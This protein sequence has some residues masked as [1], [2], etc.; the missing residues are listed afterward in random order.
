MKVIAGMSD[1][2]PLNDIGRYAQHVE[3]LGYDMLHI[4]ET[5]HDSMAVA[6]LALEHTTTLRV[7]TSLTLAFPRSPMLLALQAWDLSQMSGGRF[8]LGLATQIKQ[9]IEGRFGIPWSSPIRKMNDYVIAVKTAWNS[10]ATGD[11]FIVDTEQYRM[12]RLQPFFNPGPLPHDGPQLLL[13]G[14]NDNA[15][16]LAGEVADWFVTH[17]TNSHPRFLRDRALPRLAEGINTAN[18][19]SNDVQV[20]IAIPYITGLNQLAVDQSRDAQRA[21]LGFLYSTPAYRRTLELFG[22]DDLGAQL[23]LMTRSGDWSQLGLLMT[24]EVL[25]ALIPSGTWN[26]LPSVINDWFGGLVDAVLIQPSDD[27]NDEF[28]ELIQRVKLIE[29]RLNAA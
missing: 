27:F 18:R 17:P 23:Q 1:R 22:W 15:V 14:V 25:D 29:S 20:A 21:V 13:G 26:K 19:T 7:Q 8:D 2:I 12:N 11:P 28:A 4:P 6:L 24:D 5:I 3:A 9:N 10:F 16:R